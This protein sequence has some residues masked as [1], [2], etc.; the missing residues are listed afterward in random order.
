MV[1]EEGGLAQGTIHGRT[2]TVFRFR[3]QERPCRTALI[4]CVRCAKLCILFHYLLFTFIMY[5]III[6][7][8]CFIALLGF[9]LLHNCISDK[10]VFDSNW[11]ISTEFY[12]CV[13]EKQGLNAKPKLQRFLFGFAGIG[14][15][16]CCWC[17]WLG[18]YEVAD[19][20]VGWWRWIWTW[21]WFSLCWRCSGSDVCLF[22]RSRPLAVLVLGQG[23]SQGT[24]QLI[25]SC[26]ANTWA[27]LRTPSL[28]VW[29]TPL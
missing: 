18:A 7:C 23:L 2:A 4:F 1:V 16:W 3:R 28:G 13:L 22:L 20:L 29:E 6:I 15:F 9:K 27:Y 5:Y 17:C 10:S 24:G 25:K 21:W 11:V 19:I 14:A 12:S 26:L 8:Y